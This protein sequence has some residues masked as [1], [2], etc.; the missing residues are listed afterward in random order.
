M[1]FSI[2]LG[3]SMCKPLVKDIVLAFPISTIW[4]LLEILVNSTLQLIDTLNAQVFDFGIGFH[5]VLEQGGC[6]FASNTTS[7]IHENLLPLHFFLY[8][9]SIQPG[10][11]FGRFSHFGI[12]PFRR[13]LPLFD[14]LSFL[15]WDKSSNGSF[16]MIPHINNDSIGFA[17]FL[18]IVLWFQM[19]SGKLGNRWSLGAFQT[20]MDQFHHLEHFEIG[21]FLGLWQVGRQFEFRFGKFGRSES[22]EGATVF[23]NGFVGSRQ[24]A[25][26]TFSCHSHASRQL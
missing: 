4:E 7:T 23:H 10:W 5:F 9:W 20:I 14:A 21:K 6:S 3:R 16:V 12:Q 19:R 26:H 18:V 17:Q 15:G 25:I 8:V 1:Q 2:N 22:F 24:C 11:E 13:W